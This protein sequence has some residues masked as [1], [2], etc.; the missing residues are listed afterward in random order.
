M[1]GLRMKKLFIVLCLL[2][3]SVSAF[4]ADAMVVTRVDYGSHDLRVIKV[5]W[6]DSPALTLESQY[7]GIDS[8]IEGWYLFKV[9]TVP[10]AGAAQPDDDYDITITDAEGLDVMGGELANRDE[11]NAEEA[12]PKIDAVY[13]PQPSISSW[14][15]T[16]SGQATAAATGEIYMF[17]ARY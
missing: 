6:V 10:G 8:W 15:I 17:F 13:G 7:S 3:F 5:D 16:V 4:A 9:Q 2:M 14:T 12:V 1:K 11:T